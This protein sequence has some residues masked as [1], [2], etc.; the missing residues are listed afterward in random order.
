LNERVKALDI[1]N[2]KATTENI[3]NG[4]YKIKR[5]F[6]IATKG[7]QSPSTEDF[8]NFILSSDGQKIIENTG[9]ISATE[10]KKFKSEMPKGKITIAGSSSVAP[11]ME[12]LK[13]SYEKINN[14]VTIE[15]NP[16]DSTTGI[17]GVAENIIDIGMASRELKKSEIQKNL[18]HTAIAYDGIVII[19]N[20][21]NPI[22]QTS[23]EKIKKIYT[24]KITTWKELTK[25]SS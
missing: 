13:E 7:T 16:S 14:N 8:I 18:K 4:S 23:A 25:E 20:N 21:K 9:Y 11:V 5:P 10:K 17:N 24:G 3:K 15:I 19:I 6:N 1:D 12:K 2:A 22:T